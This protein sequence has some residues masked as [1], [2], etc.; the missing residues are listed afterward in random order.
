MPRYQTLL[1]SLQA[2]PP[3]TPRSFLTAQRKERLR[4][5]KPFLEREAARVPE[6]ASRQDLF[7]RLALRLEAIPHSSKPQR[8]WVH[9]AGD[10]DEI[11]KV[12]PLFSLRLTPFQKAVLASLYN[13]PVDA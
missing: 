3:V 6:P 9:C 8:L 1:A 13:S 2:R 10:F 5:L 4:R 12:V 7:F 11:W